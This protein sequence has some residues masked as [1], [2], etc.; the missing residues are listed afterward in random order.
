MST[1]TISVVI[2]TFNEEK[3]ISDCIESFKKIADEFVVVD[4]FSTDKTEE[5]CKNH[6]VNFIKHEW[7]GYSKTKNFANSLA[8][9]DYIFSIDADERLSLELEK[10]VLEVKKKGFIGTYSFNRLTNYCGKWIRYS[11]WY[12]DKKLRIFPKNSAIW[13]GNFVHETLKITEDLPNTHLSGDLLHYSYRTKAEHFAKTEKYAELNAQKMYDAGRKPSG[14]LLIFSPIVKFIYTF[15]FRL[16]F[17][18]KFAGWSIAVMASRGVF[19]KYK[20]LKNLYK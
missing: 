6:G 1:K 12:P 16:G 18:D 20:K 4:S 2:I 3:N 9:S 14:L 17:L 5:I 7:E 19:L 10:S 11:G 8:K 13:E 15:F